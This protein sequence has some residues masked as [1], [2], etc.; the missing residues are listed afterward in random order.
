MAKQTYTTGQL[1]LRSLTPSPSSFFSCFL[2]ALFIVFSVII[3]Q[4]VNIGTALPGVLDGEWAIWYTEHVVQPL[5]TFLSN[6]TFNKSFV[7]LIWGLAGFIVYIAFE[8]GTHTLKTYRQ[9]RHDIAIQQGRVV[10]H[11]MQRD[12]NRSLIWRSGIV[13]LAIVFL[14][15]VQPMLKNAVSVAPQFVMSQDLAADGIK[16]LLAIVEW[17]V[18][19]H[20]IVVLIRLYTMRTR[21]FGDDKLY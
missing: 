2:A 21:I 1:V 20:G 6:A 7:A 15:A 11:P 14:I 12:F 10:M 5:T 8:V 4:S 18:F 13:L 16:V 17:M 19:W 9:T 3:L